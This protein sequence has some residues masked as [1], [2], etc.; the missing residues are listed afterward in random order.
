MKLTVKGFRC[1]IVVGIRYRNGDRTG[2]GQRR[3]IENRA[4]AKSEGTGAGT[5]AVR[6]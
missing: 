6:K 1:G 4:K 3:Q 5:C 2:K